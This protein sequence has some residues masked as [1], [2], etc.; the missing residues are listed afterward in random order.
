MRVNCPPG[1]SFATSVFGQTGGSMPDITQQQTYTLLRATSRESTGANADFRKLT[2]GTTLTVLDA[3]G[4]GMISHMWFTIASNEPY[5]LKR[6]I[7]RIYW[8]GEDVSQR[9][10]PHRRLLR[11]RSRQL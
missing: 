9:R 4:P 10:S 5:H 2:P 6:I 1:L 3:D 8:D 11:P 7:L